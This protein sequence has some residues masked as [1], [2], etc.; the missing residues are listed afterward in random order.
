MTDFQ[1]VQPLVGVEDRTSDILHSSTVL[2]ISLCLG[3]RLY[4]EK[5]FT[6]WSYKYRF[7]QNGPCKHR[8]FLVSD[9]WSSILGVV[10]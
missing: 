8:C 6:F 4:Y 9:N 7:D 5:S 3:N 2:A 10:H 1:S